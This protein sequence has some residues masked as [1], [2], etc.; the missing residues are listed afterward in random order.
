MIWYTSSKRT[1]SNSLNVKYENSLSTTLINKEGKTIMLLWKIN[2][3]YK[4]AMRVFCKF[5]F[6]TIWE[7]LNIPVNLIYL[8]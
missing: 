7:K 4:Y 6:Y 3:P 8:L 5:W 2:S 1:D